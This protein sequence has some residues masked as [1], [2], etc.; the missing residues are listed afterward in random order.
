M[1]LYDWPI[2][3][4]APKP[5]RHWGPD[6]SYKIIRVRSNDF[7]W[8][9]HLVK[10]VQA[11]HELALHVNYPFNVNQ[12]TKEK[13]E[14][15]ARDWIIFAVLSIIQLRLCIILHLIIQF[16]QYFLSEHYC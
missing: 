15:T 13:E 16:L 5:T 12:T 6:K 2:P 1:N 4:P 7:I 11:G 3:N 9:I 14:I 8:I 10:Y